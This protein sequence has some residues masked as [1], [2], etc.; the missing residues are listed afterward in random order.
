MN[1]KEGVFR[2]ESLFLYYRYNCWNNYSYTYGNFWNLLSSWM[3]TLKKEMEEKRGQFKGEPCCL[4]YIKTW[5][6]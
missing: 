6:L 5:A 2:I 4:C 1:E 3:D